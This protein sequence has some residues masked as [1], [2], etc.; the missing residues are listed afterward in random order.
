MSSLLQKKKKREL[1]VEISRIL[2]FSTVTDTDQKSIEFG[3]SSTHLRYNLVGWGC[4]IHGLH[5]CRGL[6]PHPRSVLI[7]NVQ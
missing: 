6:I 5:L 3:A 2:C 4:G 7:V 1:A